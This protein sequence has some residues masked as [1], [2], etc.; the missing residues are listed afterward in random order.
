M[1]ISLFT[2]LLSAQPAACP[3]SAEML[4]AFTAKAELPRGF[5]AVSAGGTKVTA[6]AWG[7][8]ELAIVGVQYRPTFAVAVSCGE[9]KELARVLVIRAKSESPNAPG[10][11][12]LLA[13]IGV[14]AQRFVVGGA[15]SVEAI[16]LD[17]DGRAEIILDGA[18][19]KRA[20][21]LWISPRARAGEQ[22][23]AVDPE[24]KAR[25]KAGD[26]IVA[27][28]IAPETGDTYFRRWRSESELEFSVGC[29]GTE[30]RYIY[31]VKSKATRR[32]IKLSATD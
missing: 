32:S 6:R 21:E 29:C 17:E 19:D 5:G 3:S 2:A 24:K 26:R 30:Q 1:Q 20:K 22:V 31:D 25:I 18:V 11:F 12:E 10:G 13:E 28:L 9:A 23:R 7:H 14:E 27:G 16:D 8:L 15:R 4:A